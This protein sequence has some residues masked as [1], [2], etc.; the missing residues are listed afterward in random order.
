MVDIK[1]AVFDGSYHEVDSSEIA[2]KI[3][4]SQ[5]MQTAVKNAGLVL[6]EPIMKAEV[7]TP[8]EFMGTVIGDLSSRRA[9]ILGTEIRNTT[10]IISVMVPLSEIS[11]YSTTLRSLTQGRANYYM[12]PS[13]Y[14]E[15]PKSVTEAIIA[16]KS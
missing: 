11:G 10:R 16:K 8:E 6:L 12:E 2:F 15:V 13:H 7:T 14:Q 3:A 4:G 1:V 5:A 9:Q